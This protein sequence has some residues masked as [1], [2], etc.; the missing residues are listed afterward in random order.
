MHPRWKTPLTDL[1]KI[2]YPIVLGPFGGGFSSAALT[3]AVTN[4][5]GLGSY[6]AHHHTAEEIEAVDRE[7]R[8]LT[9]GPYCINLW[10]KKDEPDFP[11]DE[12][13]F[14]RLKT[15]FR[16]YFDELGVPLPSMPK[17]NVKTTFHYQ[18]EAILRTR[19]A[20]FSFVFG[21]PDPTVMRALK[22]RGILTL[23]GATTVD[24][25]LALEEAGTDL[26]AATGFEAGGHRV[27]F[28]RPAEESL[29]GT[30]SLVPLV[31]DRVNVP[32]IAAG[33]VSDARGIAAAMILGA[34][35]VQVGTAFLACTESNATP[36][37]RETLFSK[38]GTRTVLTRA[39]SGRLARGMASRISEETSRH[40]SDFA[41]YPLHGM[42][43]RPLQQAANAQH[44]EDLITFWAGQSYPL[45]RHRSAREVFNALVEGTEKIWNA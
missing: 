37:H 15:L 27:S 10:M 20:V 42:F 43:I 29:M 45:I 7:I 30:F 39:F 31:A 23:G 19:P 25:A 12:A 6:G 13:A 40:A 36:L 4:L 41:P 32:V 18:V 38:K 14:D 21:I 16:P 17:M 22:Q 11:M 8:S 26:I 2:S 5:G 24:E 35:A 1:L 3:A 33:G 44:R 9:S 34:D 28:L